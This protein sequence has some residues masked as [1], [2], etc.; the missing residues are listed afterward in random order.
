MLSSG[1][2]VTSSATPDVRWVQV[3][4]LAPGGPVKGYSDAEAIAATAAMDRY[5]GSEVGEARA[6]LVCR[7]S[8]RQEG[9]Q[10]DSES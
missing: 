6:A 2:D 5:R 7:W 3:G 9:G 1:R 8:Q 4:D 10:E